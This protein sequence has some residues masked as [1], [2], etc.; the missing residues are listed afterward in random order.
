MGEVTESPEIF[1]Q[2]WSKHPS[3]I[4]VSMCMKYPAYAFVYYLPFANEEMPEIVE[5]AQTNV[6][7]WDKLFR[8]HF[9]PASKNTNISLRTQV[10]SRGAD[11]GMDAYQSTSKAISWMKLKPWSYQA[12]EWCIFKIRTF[13]K[14]IDVYAPFG[15]IAT[16]FEDPA[17][18]V[19]LVGTKCMNHIVR[20]APAIVGEMNYS[21]YLLQLLKI[22]LSFHQSPTLLNETIDCI[23]YQMD[24][25]YINHESIYS[26]FFGD[27][28]EI[29]LHD[30]YQATVKSASFPAIVD[31]L[32]A[33]NLSG[34]SNWK[35][36]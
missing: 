36:L 4:D 1:L 19:R 12:F 26:E 32:T 11:F 22:N 35:S 16:M 15:V 21:L 8:N 27:F 7:E 5:W 3:A 25:F 18:D 14:T 2:C 10:E 28:M 30:L 29:I 20:T 13:P 9:I 24:T 33:F 17:I 23:I 34:V 31:A 6:P